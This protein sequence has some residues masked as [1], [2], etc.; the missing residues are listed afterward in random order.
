MPTTE[1]FSTAGKLFIPVEKY[2]LFT[3]A[4][5]DNLKGIKRENG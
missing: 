4:L 3:S 5:I 2:S 1:I